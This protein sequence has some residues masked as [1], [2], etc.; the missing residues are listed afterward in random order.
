MND[1]RKEL[2]LTLALHNYRLRLQCPITFGMVLPAG[3]ENAFQSVLA[4]RPLF[5]KFLGSQSV[6]T[7]SRT[8]L[9]DPWRHLSH[10]LLNSL[11]NKESHK[12][13]RAISDSE[14]NLLRITFLWQTKAEILTFC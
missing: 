9:P 11:N 6:R 7:R 1:Y 5:S 8:S 10:S 12:E 4:V 14:K 13:K 3:F 2:E